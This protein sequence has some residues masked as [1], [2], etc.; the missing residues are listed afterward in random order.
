MKKLFTLWMALAATLSMSATTLFLKAN[1]NWVKDNAR[2]AVFANDSWFDMTAVPGENNI[3]SAVVGSTPEKATFYRMNPATSENT[4]ANAWNKTSEQSV[5]YGENLYIMD[6]GTWGDGGYW[7]KYSAT[8][9]TGSL[10]LWNGIGSA[11]NPTQIGGDSWVSKSDERV[12]IGAGQRGNC[13]LKINGDIAAG[14]YIGIEL[15]NGGVNAEDQIVLADFRTSDD[16]SYRLSI[17]FFADVNAS[18]PQA[19]FTTSADPQ[20]LAAEGAP[21]QATFTV[22]AGVADATYLRVCRTSGEASIWVAKLELIKQGSDPGPGPGPGP[23]PEDPKVQFAGEITGWSGEAFTLAADKKTATF[24]KNIAEGEHEFKIIVGD[25]DW[26]SNAQSFD[27]DNASAAGITGNESTNMKLIADATGDYTFTWTIATNALEINFPAKEGPGPEPQPEDPKVQFAGE[28]T[29]WSGEAF[30]L[31]AD[32]KTA[33]FTKN[34]AEGEHEFKI[35]VG[36][37]DWRSN[38][39]SF[40][41]DNASAAG[42]T[43]NEST[44]MKLIADATGDYTFTWTI[45]TNALEINFPAKEGPGP[46]PE[47]ED[48]KVQF[49][50][51]IT[52]WSGEAFTL[53]A[54]KKTATFTKNIAE[55]EHEFKIIVGDNDW[56][57]NGWTYHREFTHADGITMNDDANMKLQADVTG[58]YTFTWTFETN[59]LDILFPEKGDTPPAGLLVDG[60]YLVGTI[61]N[62][63]PVAE[64][65]FELNTGSEQEE[66]ELNILLNAGDEIKAVKVENEN[67][68]SWYPAE[69]GNLVVDADHAGQKTVYFRPYYDGGDGWFAGCL[70]IPANGG[71]GLNDLNASEKAVKV[72][73]DG[74][75]FIIKGNKTFNVLG[76]QLD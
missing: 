56:R 23:E 53:A 47:P 50:G 15:K 34:I 24:T 8:P 45:A 55:G 40:D 62:W 65:H 41:R 48:P 27:R 16:K 17:Q 43:G 37:N 20:V 5:P 3:F 64:N 29:G 51:E 13:N 14:Y 7:S 72:I 19:T 67:I 11:S 68:V 71:E 33:T 44:N 6:A 66:Y 60:Y 2:F 73:R 76:A 58:D 61:T 46:E 74:Q 57:S 70:Y 1:D 38:A 4:E 69:G 10:Y 42:I 35:I 52:G 49:A 32:K 28:I 31:A 30:T 26:R 12:L 25:N 75:I 63:S 9:A 21:A 18:S 22:P 54:D 39:Q 59:S 36:D